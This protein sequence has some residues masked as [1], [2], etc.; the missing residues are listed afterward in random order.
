MVLKYFCFFSGL[1]PVPKA[2]SSLGINSTCVGISESDIDSLLAYHYIHGKGASAVALPA[3]RQELY[4][5]LSRFTFVSGGKSADLRD[6]SYEKL[7]KLYVA[8]FSTKNMGAIEDI[9]SLPST[10]DIMIY[11]CKDIAKLSHVKR[12]LHATPEKPKILLLETLPKYAKFLAEW[13][14]DL[15]NLGYYSV[16][17]TLKAAQC[18]VPVL[19]SRYFVISNPIN[20]SMDFEKECPLR[21]AADFLKEEGIDFYEKIDVKT[22]IPRPDSVIP[23]PVGTKFIK[24]EG[25]KVYY[26]DG[27]LPGKN[28]VKI[29][30]TDMSVRY[31]TPVE[32]W[33][34]SGFNE[35]DYTNVK[36]NIPYLAPLSLI[37]LATASSPV[38]L[39]TEIFKHLFVTPISTVSKTLTVPSKML[40]KNLKNNA[41]TLLKDK[42]EKKCINKLYGYV[43]EVVAVENIFEAYISKA[44]CSNRI[45]VTYT[46]RSVKPRL[47]NTYFGKVKGCYATGILSDIKIFSD[48]GFG[49]K[50]FI[51]S[52]M[53][54][55]KTKV[56]QFST[57]LCEFGTGDD[58]FFQLTELDYNVNKNAFVCVGT[59]K[60]KKC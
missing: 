17:K 37:K 34:L 6:F 42:Y 9:Q 44:D 47:N 14:K 39:F 21:T 35:S 36:L 26:I 10:C 13:K 11:C 52:D 33:L 43:L 20:F 4:E 46:I 32:H 29:A 2:L 1:G 27:V 23:S 55:E 15:A 18:G 48:K 3:S 19:K 60:C 53:F 22:P 8:H 25:H 56:N 49:C 50:V 59:H 45:F 28:F 7:S 31:L 5:Q 57:C 51:L 58:I 30:D 41:L 40:G 54:D 12:I 16:S 38:Y 24:I